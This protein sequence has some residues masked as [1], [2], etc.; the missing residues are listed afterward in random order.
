[1]K[2]FKPIPQFHGHSHHSLDGAA[3]VEDLVGRAKEL[4]IPALAIT[5][6]G[7]LNSAMELYT[8]GKKVGVLPV[9]GIEAYVEDEWSPEEFDKR[10]VLKKKYLHL[11]LHFKTQ[12]AYEYFCSL[13]PQMEARAVVKFGERKPILKLA[14]L[15]PMVGEIT[16][17][18]GCMVGCVC[19]FLMKG[20]EA[21]AATMYERL[22]NLAGPGN[23]F[24][25]IFPHAV[26]HNWKSPKIDPATKRFVEPGQFIKNE[27]TP[28]APDGD[29]QKSLNKWLIDTAHKY[30]DPVVPSLDYHFAR[31]EQ[32]L[33]QNARLGQGMELWQFYNSYHIKDSD[34]VGQF[35]M[36]SL[37]VNTKTVESWIDNAHL[38]ASS[39]KDFKIPTSADRWVMP[40][41]H[42]DSME[43]IYELINKN[44]KMNWSDP[45]MV[46]RLKYEIEALKFNGKLD[47]LPYFFPIADLTEWC[48]D[49]N[50][51]FQLRGSGSGSLLVYLIGISDFNPM[52]HGLSFDRFISKGRVASN[53][54]PDLDLDIGDRDRVLKHLTEKYGD[55]IVHI[56]TDVKAKLKSAI[57]DA[58][59]TLLGSVTKNTEDLCRAIPDP[60]QGVDE[61]DYVF[62]GLDMDGGLIEGVFNSSEALQKYAAQN[63][64]TWAMVKEF[65]GIMR[66]KS[67]HACGF[68]ITDKPAQQYIPLYSIAKGQIVTGFSPKSIEAAGLVK[69]DFLGLNTLKDIATAFKLVEER[70]GIKYDRQNIPDDPEVYKEFERGNTATVFQFNTAAVIP[71]LRR[72]KPS[73]IEDLAAITALVRPG[74]LDA[75][76]EDGRTLAEVYVARRNGEPVTYIHPDLEPVLKDTYGI[77]LF[78]ESQ[79]EIFKRIGGYSA[80]EAEKVR[81]GIGKK[82]AKILSTETKKLKIAC[83]ARGWNEQQSQ[84]LI[85]QIMAAASYGFNKSHAASYAY[86]ARACM[87]LKTKYPIE[88]WTAV[89]SN[90][91]KNELP[92]FWAH[93]SHMATLPDINKSG[94][95]WVIDGSR[96]IAPIGI[97][98][99]IGEIAYEQLLQMK[100]FSSIDDY[101]E[102]VKAS[103]SRAVHKGV[104]TK[105]ILSGVMDSLFPENAT[106]EEKL[107]L[108]YE[109]KAKVDGKKP[110]KVPEEYKN[111]SEVQ[112]YANKKQIVPIYSQDQRK[113]VLPK[114][115]GTRDSSE[116]PV[117]FKEDDEGRPEI[118]VSTSS[119]DT[120]VKAVDKETFINPS[121]RPVGFY[122]STVSYVV[123][124]KTKSY[125]GKT[126]QMTQLMLDTCGD[127]KEAVLWPSY[128]GTVAETG[129]KDK[130]CIVKWKYNV[131]RREYGIMSID[132]INIEDF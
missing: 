5:E 109:A 94:E 56:S 68:C 64:K 16:I 104:T 120:M 37:K 108:Y 70:H 52:K 75:I 82:D 80:E 71:F 73:N 87:F 53:S 14:E 123:E 74:T 54:L 3:T 116:S 100:P 103:G 98:K 101:A 89:L 38:W 50:I 24:V 118:F 95:G 27:C 10:N 28:F 88:W 126:K 63:P 49:S 6:H 44:G 131:K 42:G 85:E 130:I 106:E 15:E 11:T 43:K 61:Y 99:G 8:A 129:F 113:L 34:E 127:F 114:L 105:L 17:G 57:K 7:N 59:R 55:K 122:I 91:D 19:K 66:N 1:M 67:S 79:L 25:E 97:L 46:E 119:F 86:T 125:Q 93:C 83:L 117:W 102:K 20:D 51:L 36:D 76:A 23:F 115:G 92:K 22:R 96:I 60:P 69:Y 77:Q 45:L 18:S 111:L 72:I 32:K 30:G 2:K 40:E 65:L 41:F 58:E 39:F 33:S 78:Q 48:R 62:G 90:A 4:E 112:K 132:P 21:G 84:L 47:V 121:A 29:L 31:P 107:T 9:L 81:R 13:T 26:T 128:E 110:E 124:E 12:R 35:F